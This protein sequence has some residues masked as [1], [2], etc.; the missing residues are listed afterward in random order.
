ME[1]KTVSN[2]FINI[3]ALSGGKIMCVWGYVRVSTIQQKTKRQ[4]DNI[5]AF[6]KDAVIFTE[7]QSGKNIENREVFR[8]LL[9]KV[10]ADDT[11]VFDEVSR[12]SRN[13]EEGYS[14]YMELM[15]RNINLVFLKERHIDT[16]EY[17]R[18]ANKHIERISTE[19][20][21]TD[22]LI[23]GILDLAV[24]FEREN[25]KDN[26]RLAFEQAEHERTFLIKRVT[27]GKAKSENHQ[28]RPKGSLN[29]N[30]EKGDR[31]KQIIREQSK[32]FEGKFSDVK[33]MTDYL[34]GV[35]RNTFYKYK[36]ELKTEL[37]AK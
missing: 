9:E 24:E 36:R 10:K 14:L 3:F 33:I 23:N 16:A 31:I 4:E 19:N 11:I 20:S 7:K 37:Q 35:A 28:G 22:K 18:R 27:E 13:A 29:V 25:L 12:M 8:K 30:S 6:C 15:E 32:D 5:K 34:H 21:K 26:I 2:L 17:Q 1:Y